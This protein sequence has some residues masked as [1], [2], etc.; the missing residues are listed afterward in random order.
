MSWK[1]T[2]LVSVLMPMYNARP[3][4]GDAV[5]SVISQ[6]YQNWEMIALDDGSTD[7]TADRVE[8]FGDVRIRVVR[9]SRNRGLPH[10]LNQAVAL[11]NGALFARM[12]ADD[13]SYPDRFQ[14]QVSYLLANPAVDCV[15]TNMLVVTPG[16][17]PTGLE[18]WRGSSHESVVASPWA[19]FHFNHATWMGRAGW[20]R[21]YPYRE[22]AIRTEDDDLM[23][24]AFSSSR[25]HRMED[26]LYAYR[27]GPVDP[28][29]VW[30]ARRHF[31][32][33]LLEQGW[34]QRRPSLW[35]G[36]PGQL[37][38]GAAERVAGATGLLAWV[39]Q[40]RSDGKVSREVEA[41]FDRATSA[42]QQSGR[43]WMDRAPRA[44]AQKAF[45]RSQGGPIQS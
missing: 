2:P 32:Q 35:R 37:A 26:V 17:R 43:A 41:R 39:T 14:K 45:T 16:G 6:S 44:S 12:D 42:I 27:V 3:H 22:R 33:A 10:R 11:A 36:V 23:L 40:H 25:F 13:L 19:G 21:R 28:R 15:A 31:A 9:S 1:E 34:K 18:K 24:R 20:F 5:R 29:A 8:A 30:T 38:K 7:D 4:V